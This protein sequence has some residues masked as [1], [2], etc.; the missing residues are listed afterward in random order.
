MEMAPDMIELVGTCPLERLLSSGADFVVNGR[1]TS[2]GMLFGVR[3]Q[4]LYE[5]CRLYGPGCGCASWESGRRVSSFRRHEA[6][7]TPSSVGDETK[8][9]GRMAT[10]E[11]DG[12]VKEG[13]KQFEV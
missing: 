8:A 2:S 12:F 5:Q 6:G 7:M 9:S 13:S 3:W 4:S 11:R 1:K 10:R